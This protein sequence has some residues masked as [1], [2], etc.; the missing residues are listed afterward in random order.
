VEAGDHISNGRA[1]ASSRPSS[2]NSAVLD[3]QTPRIVSPIARG[4]SSSP[5][6]RNG[7]SLSARQS[8][9]DS[10]F[11]LEEKDDHEDESEPRTAVPADVAKSLR[12]PD[13]DPSPTSS[14][15][16]ADGR[17]TIPQSSAFVLSAPPAARS[18]RDAPTSHPSEDIIQ[19]SSTPTTAK[20]PGVDGGVPQLTPLREMMEGAADTSDEASSV[21]PSNDAHSMSEHGVRSHASSDS[22]STISKSRRVPEQ[23][24]SIQ[25]QIINPLRGSPPRASRD[26]AAR[27]NA[28]ESKSQRSLH[29]SGS[30]SSSN[31]HKIKPVRTSQEST[32][33]VA[34]DK[35]RSFEQLIRSDQTI[36]YTL[37]P[38]NMRNIEVGNPAEMALLKL[39]FFQAPESAA[40]TTNVNEVQRPKTSRSH[41]SSVSKRTG[42]QSQ[43]AVET[44]KSAQPFKAIPRPTSNAGSRLRA[45]APQPRDARVD[46][47]SIG[48][49]ADFIRSTGKWGLFRL[50][51]SSR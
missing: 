45:N 49:F 22:T 5:V 41:S 39:I 36:Q 19:Q 35:G 24:R 37:T 11:E 13:V 51:I 26:E 31:S 30:G 34:E 29:T 4:A 15:F 14:Q 42:S 23:E 44:P 10:I 8:A 48:D 17:G 1:R 40:V 2:I 28:T 50:N 32:S 21:A 9:R 33:T 43:S 18:L 38:Q 7:S 47:D 16:T 12:G 27:K 6:I 46:R 25:P 20:T 3:T